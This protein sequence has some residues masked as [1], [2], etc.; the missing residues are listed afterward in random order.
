[1]RRR[2]LLLLPLL[3]LACRTEDTWVTPDPHLERMLTQEKRLAYQAD[4]ALPQG[5]VMQQPP[6]GTLPVDTP[7]DE[8][9]R[10]EGAA[11]G[12]WA[13]R[14]PLPLDRTLL[15]Q[16]RRRFET[17]CAPCHGVLGD[18]HSVVAD[19]M[20]LRKPPD[21]LT[22]AVR[23]YPPGRV[24]QTVRQGMG[25]MPSYRVQ[26]TLRDTWSVVAYLGAL[27]LARGTA[28]AELPP[29]VQSELAHEAP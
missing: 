20:A 13:E 5:M 3:L 8:P 25:L 1:M 27:Q 28:V 12:H 11:N 24:F 22:S 4:P 6:D 18:G 16:G 26:L 29:D 14:I 21:L 7:L 9:L 17:F 2:P 10:V 15:D 23:A 19:K